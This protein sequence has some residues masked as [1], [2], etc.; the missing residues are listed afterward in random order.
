VVLVLGLGLGDPFCSARDLHG[1][2][3]RV[4][5]SLSPFD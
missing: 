2:R 4:M 1:E 3:C 5:W